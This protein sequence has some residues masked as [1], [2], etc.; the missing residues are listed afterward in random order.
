MI[1]AT[2]HQGTEGVLRAEA[3]PVRRISS[4]ALI[5][6]M[7][8]ELTMIFGVLV[9][10]LFWM[11]PVSTPFASQHNLAPVVETVRSS[12]SGTI[13]DPLIDI[14]PGVSARAS[15]LRGLSMGGSVYYYYVE[16]HANFD[17]LSR[18]VVASDAVE[19]ML[20]DTSGPSAIVIYR[21]R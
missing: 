18:G 16:G 15:N 12:L 5:I 11:L 8:V 4:R 10:A 14:A 19:I 9:W 1:N 3:R 17:P 7:G 20:R 21:L 2:T 6:M 13:N